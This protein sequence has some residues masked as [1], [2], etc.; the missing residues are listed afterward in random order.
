MAIPFDKKEVFTGN[1]G[2]IILS[3]ESKK[4]KE[5]HKKINNGN[6][7]SESENFVEAE[8]FGINQFNKLIAP[9]GDQCVGFRVYH[10]VTWENHK[11]KD[12]EVAAE[13]KGKKTARVII[14]PVDKYGND[15]KP[16]L[17]LK[18]PTPSEL[19]KGPLCPTSCPPPQTE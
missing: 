7:R 13:G 4:Q 17:A 2:T 11:G 5:A 9:Y 12:V 10:G 15:L 18:D 3:S 1:E 6:G 8:F 19:S 14:V 16:E